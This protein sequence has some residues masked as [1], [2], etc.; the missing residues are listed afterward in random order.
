MKINKK[1]LLMEDEETGKLFGCEYN[2]FNMSMLRLYI[3]ELAYVFRELFSLKFEE[4]FNLLILS[5]FFLCLAFRPF[6]K[7]YEYHFS[8]NK[9]MARRRERAK[10]AKRFLKDLLDKNITPTEDDYRCVYIL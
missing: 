3:D 5:R 2:D 7:I 9:E 10:K 8:K 4:Y 6:Y 1:T